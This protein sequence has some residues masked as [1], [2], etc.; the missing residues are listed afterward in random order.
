MK[1]F[2]SSTVDVHFSQNISYFTSSDSCCWKQ[3]FMKLI[4]SA[5]GKFN[6]DLLA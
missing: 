4:L 2:S 5:N 6:G 3:S 1:D